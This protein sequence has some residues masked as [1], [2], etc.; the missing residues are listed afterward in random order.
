[1]DVNVRAPMLLVPALLPHLGPRANRIINMSVHFLNRH[2]CTD[3]RLQL[4]RRKA[5]IAYST[6]S[7][8]PPSILE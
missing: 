2:I 7:A 4:Y 8:A 3:I 1:M 6:A 5:M